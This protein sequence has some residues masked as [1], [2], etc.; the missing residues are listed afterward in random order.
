MSSFG[1]VAFKVFAE[2]GAF[3]NVERDADGF[4]RYRATIQV[5]SIGEINDLLALESRAT[6]LR[7]YGRTGGNI[8]LE[9]GPGAKSLSAPVATGS[10]MT[11]SAVLLSVTNVCGDG[12][13]SHLF[14]ADAEWVLV[15]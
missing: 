6:L 2:N 10:D 7:S 11:R 13:V 14:R 12:W 3:P 5:G 9:S 15:S 8:H 1:G 4:H